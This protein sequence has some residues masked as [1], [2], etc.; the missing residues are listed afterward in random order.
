MHLGELT[1][2]VHMKKLFSLLSL[3]MVF[4]ISVACNKN[5]PQEEEVR[6]MRVEERID[7]VPA[8]QNQEDQRMEDRYQENYDQMNEDVKS[9]DEK[10]DE[11]LREAN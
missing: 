1:E 5:E 6:E 7:E 10:V 9:T 4:S 2:G 11:S 3:I 8:G